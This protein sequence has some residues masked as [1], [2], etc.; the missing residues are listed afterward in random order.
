MASVEEFINEGF[1]VLEHEWDVPKSALLKEIS[2]EFSRMFASAAKHD[3]RY[4]NFICRDKDQL[5]YDFAPNN[6]EAVLA[7]FNKKHLA[8]IKRFAQTVLDE[9]DLVMQVR[10]FASLPGA[11]SQTWHR[12]A[13][14]STKFE[15]MNFFCLLNEPSR[16]LGLTELVPNSHLRGSRAKGPGQKPR[17]TK[18]NQILAFD[19][20]VLHRGL[21]NWSTETVRYVLAIV[22]HIKSFVDKNYSSRIKML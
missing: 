22:F 9:D 12:D 8:E 16:D 11:R 1:C 21:P 17:L 4:K 2:T 15:A 19:Y 14:R 5:R 3:K 20:A 10:V 13:P 7:F 6:Q 18:P